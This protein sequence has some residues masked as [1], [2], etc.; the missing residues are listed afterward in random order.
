MGDSVLNQTFE[1][2]ELALD[3]W[4]ATTSANPLTHTSTDK[5][6]WPFY[7]FTTK[8]DAVAGFKVISAT[9]P[10]VFLTITEE[11]NKF[12]FTASGTSYTITLPSIYYTTTTLA[13][14]LATLLNAVSSG[15]SVS[16]SST[17]LKYTI[18]S[19]SSLSWSIY[20]AN[21]NTPAKYLGF[22]PETLYSASGTGSSIVSQIVARPLGPDYLYL[23]SQK[24]GPLINFNQADGGSFGGSGNPQ[25]ARIPINASYGNTIIYTDPGKKFFY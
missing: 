22:L 16:Y 11:N 7:Y 17:T 4:D 25:V 3:S 5:Y 13:S 9:I 23:N 21:R 1:Y 14:Q 2:S 6:S 8:Q 15:F 19:S 24:L 12:T 18:T 20:F 10:N